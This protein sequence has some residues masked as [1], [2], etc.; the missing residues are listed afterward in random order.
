MRMCGIR[1][2]LLLCLLTYYVD[3]FCQVSCTPPSDPQCDDKCGGVSIGL[4]TDDNS[5]FCQAE[6]VTIEI[7]KIK[8]SD[9]DSFFVYWC[10]GSIGRFGKNEYIY[11]HSYSIPEEEICK[12]KIT[13]YFIWVR[14][15]KYCSEGA[16]CRLIG[17]NLKIKHAPRA[18]FTALQ[19]VCVDKMA[20][21]QSQ[22]C[23]VDESLD[24]AYIWDF[25]DGN[26]LTGKNSNPSHQYL[27]AGQYLVKLT[28]KNSCG[29][30]MSTPQ[31]I[32]VVDYPNSDFSVSAN[33][34]NNK[35]CVGD[36]I[37]LIDK[38]NQWARN[39]NIWTFPSNN[40]LT[41]TMNWKLISSIRKKEKKAPTDTIARLDTIKFVVLKPTGMNNPLK[42]ILTADNAC[43]PPVQKTFELNV[44][45]RPTT[46]IQGNSVFCESGVYAP[47]LTNTIN[48]DSVAWKFQS[49]NP[50]VSKSINP[51]SVTFSKP[52]TYNIEA[53]V[54]Y[55]CGSI[56][57]NETVTVYSR[58]PVKI[59]KY[60]KTYCV[61]STEKDTLN[62]DR[63]GGTWKMNGAGLTSG[64]IFSPSIAGEGNYIITYTIGP[65][66]CQSMDTVHIKVV[67]SVAINIP[68]KKY[69]ED[70]NI[71][72]LTAIPPG[73]TW[74]GPGI[75]DMIKGIFDPSKAN[76]GINVIQYTY[77]DGNCISITP[78]N[79][80]IDALPAFSLK[81]SST[82][83]ADG[84]PILLTE[85]LV[86]TFVPNGSTTTF[87]INNIQVPENYNLNSLAPNT[88][89]VK[90]IHQQGECTV[91]DTGR[92]LIIAKKTLSMPPNDTLCINDGTFQLT[93]SPSGG[94]WSGPGVNPI[95]G[96]IN[97]NVAKGGIKMYNYVFEKGTSCEVSGSVNI[98]I[99][100]PANSLDIG[101]DE[102]FCFGPTTKALTAN[103]PNGMWSGTGIQP[104]NG[105]IDLT[106]LKTDTTYTYQYCIND[107][108]LNNCPACKQ[109]K[110]TI[111]SLPQAAFVKDS[112]NCIGEIITFT[113]TTSAGSYDPATVHWNFGNGN[114]SSLDPVVTQT[115]ATKNNYTVT[116]SLK[117]NNGCPNTYSQTIR[118]T[119]K[120]NV[121]TDIKLPAGD[122]APFTISALN[123][124]SADGVFSSYWTLNG[125]RYDTQNFGPITIDSLLDVK[126]Y[127][128]ALYTTNEC[129]TV[130]ESDT[131]SVRPY[132][133]VDFGIDSL[134]GCSPMRVRF[135]NTTKGRP[136]SFLWDMGNGITSTDSL[137]PAQTYTTNDTTI[138][139]YK[140]RLIA[141][142]DCGAD[143]L[144]RWV[145]VF[146]PNVRAFI[147]SPQ[148]DVCQY[149]SLTFLAYSTPSATN[150]WQIVSPTGKV[151]GI[152]GDTAVIRFEESG[153][154]KILL[155]A[156]NCGVHADSA[157]VD[158]I[159]APLLSFDIP[160]FACMNDTV[161]ITNTSPNLAGSYWDFGDGSFSNE[162]SPIHVYKTPGIYNITLTG[163]SLINNC[164]YSISQ[165]IKIVGKP[166]S[167]FTA[168]T[169]NGCQPLPIQFINQSQ[170]GLLYQ[171]DFGDGSGIATDKDPRHTFEKSGTFVV[172]LTVYDENNCFTDTAVVNVI[173]HPKPVAD[174]TFEDKKYCLGYDSLVVENKS[175]GAAGYVWKFQNQVDT[176]IH[177]R[178][179]PNNFGSFDIELTATS[180]RNCKDTVVKNI[181]ILPSPKADFAVDNASGC[182][183]LRVS[184]Q[185]NSLHSDRYIWYFGNGVS[186]VNKDTS[187][188]YT[189]HSSYTAS[190]VAINDNGCPQDTL[191]RE[192]TVHPK[193]VADFDFAKDKECGVPMHVVFTNQ[194][195]YYND[196]QWLINGAPASQDLNFDYTFTEDKTYNITLLVEN[197]FYCKDTAQN[198]VNIYHQPIADFNVAAQA[199]E[200]EKVIIENLSQ[201]AKAYTWTIDG[202]GNTNVTSPK[203]IFDEA[204]QYH[205]RLIAIY[206]ALCQD[207]LDT[208]VPI[209]VYTKPTAD[210]DYTTGYNNAIKGEVQFRHLA[211]DF[212]DLL[213][214]FG[215]DFTSD[216]LNPM[217]EYDINRPIRVVLYA[218]NH[219]SGLY[220]CT[221]SIAK[222]IEPEW[223]K[224]FY[225]PNA[226]VPD[227][228]DEL[229]KVF[230][231]VGVG[232]A[233]YHLS[234]FSP[235]GEKVWESSALDENGSP[236]EAWDGKYGGQIVAQGAYTWRAD[237]VWQDGNVEKV[238]VGSVV[239]VR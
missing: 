113:N 227:H 56:K 35:I 120:P 221:D 67:K 193:P 40:V 156:A 154:Y 177:N 33:V 6:N 153:R 102:T 127:T 219:N 199:C 160:D 123:L 162:S 125:K 207:T 217:H 184:F 27:T 118:V 143:T 203:I 222:T 236:T 230:K 93:A 191:T 73:G 170:N 181:N 112:T 57:L 187:Y 137:P 167:S 53:T 147:E 215:D 60:K 192:I 129:G 145:K 100:D 164:D 183:D 210:F 107:S 23:N 115:Y 159:A 214:H 131:F 141:L 91:S 55:P 110:I 30:H 140:I 212:T 47:T 39:I 233:K 29:S 169:F 31:I 24:D 155:Y 79:I 197:E 168:E 12:R 157:Y 209:T 146:P 51:G 235:W 142:N 90:A 101:E 59:S 132:P 179:W 228:A 139:Q 61:T 14:G 190:L 178:F 75:I 176:V 28:V 106:Q 226:L 81:D 38:S 133:R 9:F 172:S 204:G 2:S 234:I 77:D 86:T 119:T 111:L 99:N 4:S 21:F 26:T 205:I 158:V 84:G 152:S 50:G 186:S 104:G 216:S 231:P 238:I 128:L 136:T 208:A 69:C 89:N 95:T 1:I 44:I 232:M 20:S 195:T 88:Y 72:T 200:R 126:K 83:C 117:G 70:S 42:F 135:S 109:K 62:A 151:A 36:T 17:V 198:Q 149:D 105:I 65:S 3:S 48:I 237:I 229:I 96:V 174:F 7:D 87:Y 134:Q 43:G 97:L 58:D 45:D 173:I 74:M 201:Q 37:C 161:D 202:K 171:W 68:S 189:S 82:F 175:S 165:Q 64:G 148:N 8:T 32:N 166:T 25:G 15:K 116:L 11:T 185:N 163:R 124:S 121:D 5:I 224:T 218:Y 211:R 41:D 144:D 225:A 10:D 92:I 138:T 19:E 239:V 182:E 98:K 196:A 22:S 16:S 206:N 76:G 180:D 114:T 80:Q 220:T 94:T 150:T 54:Y 223:I 85:E 194:T 63:P 49:G 188:V 108:E 122:C 71:D 34:V 66:E 13:E 103:V 18:K 52:G 213:W 46:N 78:A 130:S